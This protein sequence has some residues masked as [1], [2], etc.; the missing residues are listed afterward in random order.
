M[1]RSR[2]ATLARW[3]AAIAAAA[4]LLT[5]CWD[6]IPLSDR[7]TVLVM[8]LDWQGR[9]TWLWRFYFPN[10]VVTVSSLAQISPSQELYT[11]SATAPTIAAAYQLIQE[12]QA[13]DLYLGQ[14]QDVVWSANAPMEAVR[15]FVDAFNREG[16]TPKS[17]YV[18]V[19]RRPL[20]RLMAPTPEEVVPSLYL[21][22]FFN[23]AQCQPIPLA[24]RFW[25]F[26]DAATTPGVSPVAPYASDTTRIAQIAVYGPSGPPTIFSQA[27]TRGYGFLTGQVTKETLT[28]R[29]NGG[30][31]GI[32][33]VRGSA[34]TTTTLRG[35]R[36]DVVVTLD[37]SGS[38]A[39]WPEGGPLTPAGLRAIQ[40]AAAR[41]ILHDCQA[42]LATA[43]R[44]R[45]DPFGF[46]RSYLYAHPLVEPTH[47]ASWWDRLPID[48]R[49]RVHVTLETVGVSA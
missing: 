19:S 31:V 39:Q 27:A 47:P 46:V 7:A 41:N 44:S 25:Q 29:A 13:R 23:C 49:V 6:Q 15:T 5:G 10:P 17:A 21:T 22:Q 43:A 2:R 8:T 37:V 42:A 14:L 45:T 16:L 30:L 20:R 34:V 32:T 4:V 36:L 3:G 18:V 48:A 12:R 9:G 11:I 40:R 24:E 35:Q 33:R 38:V 1:R 28:V 26:W